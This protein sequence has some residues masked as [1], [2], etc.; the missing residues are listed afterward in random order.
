MEETPNLS[1]NPDAPRRACGPSFVALFLPKRLSSS[2]ESYIPAFED[3]GAEDRKWFS[4]AN[5]YLAW[6]DGTTGSGT[7][8]LVH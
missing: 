1:L 7:V 8:P 4:W 5:D 3:P 2:I 6:Y